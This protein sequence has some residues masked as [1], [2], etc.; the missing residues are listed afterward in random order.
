MLI[1]TKK[2]IKSVNNA[3]NL[4]RKAAYGPVF[5][6]RKSLRRGC[7]AA[8]ATITLSLSFSIFHHFENAGYQSP[9]ALATSSAVHLPMSGPPVVVK[10][11]L[12][13]PF[14]YILLQKKYE[15][16]LFPDIGVFVADAVYMACSSVKGTTVFPASV[17]RV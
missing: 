3:V 9:D 2:S 8:D 4:L 11:A 14:P 7:Q 13:P 16:K 1:Y 12:Y 5:D 6:V 15:V 10:V 17:R